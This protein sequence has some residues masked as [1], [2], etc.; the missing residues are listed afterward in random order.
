MSTSFN[1]ELAQYRANR[2]T[3]RF[4]VSERVAVDLIK[5]IVMFRAGSAAQRKKRTSTPEKL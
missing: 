2:G 4:P 5:R 1:R 3:I